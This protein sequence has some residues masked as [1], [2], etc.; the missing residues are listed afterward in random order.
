MTLPVKTD[1][2][3][4]KRSACNK[5]RASQVL[6]AYTRSRKL[7]REI[8]EFCAPAKWEYGGWDGVRGGNV[9]GVK[10]E[11]EKKGRRR[12]KGQKGE[13]RTAP[14]FGFT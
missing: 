11:E 4:H 7:K 8:S 10:D 3:A 5:S 12:E 14:C 6:D 1:Y 9:S 2:S 13:E